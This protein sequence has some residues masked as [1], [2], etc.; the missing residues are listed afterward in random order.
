MTDRRLP[1]IIRPPEP[2]EW[3]G[4]DTPTHT[5]YCDIH[6]LRGVRRDATQDALSTWV[7]KSDRA[8][9]NRC[10]RVFGDRTPE[11]LSRRQRMGKP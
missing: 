6:A 11:K 4:C 3:P 1:P 8:R 5:K 10:V 9:P 2:C 7:D